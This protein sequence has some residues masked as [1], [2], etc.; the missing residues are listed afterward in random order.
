M[1][2]SA[3]LCVFRETCG[4]ALALEH[5]GDLYSCD[6]L[7]LPREPPGQHHGGPH[8]VPGHLIQ[9]GS[10]R[11]KQ[12]RPPPPLLPGMRGPVRLQRRV[13]QTPLHSDTAWGGGAQLSLRR[14]QA[15]LQP[16][17]PLHAFHGGRASPGTGP[18]QRHVLG[19]AAGSG[20]SGK[21]STRKKRSLPLRKVARSTRSAAAGADAHY[22]SGMPSW[23]RKAI[24]EAESTGITVHPREAPPDR[25]RP[26]LSPGV[27]GGS[28]KPR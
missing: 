28:G 1:G 2:M 21:T 24:N 13:S 19:P 12:A 6:P 11:P 3:S 18:G 5:N 8:G 25:W 4:T 15:L 17:R 16:Y 27:P 10:I 23:P 14:I 22:G 7:R 9:P 20:G 26:P